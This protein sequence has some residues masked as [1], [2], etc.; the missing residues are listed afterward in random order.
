M[1]LVC[2]V[3]AS[4]VIASNVHAQST[5]GNAGQPGIFGDDGK[6]GTVVM[7]VGCEAFV[8]KSIEAMNKTSDT[9]DWEDD[10]KFMCAKGISNDLINWA[11]KEL[12][13]KIQKLLRHDFLRSIQLSATTSNRS[14]D[15]VLARIN[16]IATIYQA[17]ENTSP[18]QLSCRSG[19]FIDQNDVQRESEVC[20]VLRPK[21]EDGDIA[22]EVEAKVFYVIDGKRDS[23]PLEYNTAKLSSE[24]KS[25]EGKSPTYDF[26]RH[27]TSQGKLF[28][29]KTV[30]SC[31][32]FEIIDSRGPYGIAVNYR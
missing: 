28:E 18:S 6:P 20:F 15:G 27:A 21:L 22:F 19:Y 17:V 30:S 5:D 3:I 11:S 12:D 23:N 10:A 31:D 24:P 8:R 13:S 16:N 26:N 2:L 14:I 4:F 32:R 7:A 9:V 29:I 1:R 25:C